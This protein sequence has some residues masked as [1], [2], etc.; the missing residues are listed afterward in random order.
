MYEFDFYQMNGLTQYPGKYMKLQTYENA[1]AQKNIEKANR[2][3]EKQ[4]CTTKPFVT[5]S[6]LFL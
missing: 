3:M 6:V 4:L 2:S 1:E 5:N